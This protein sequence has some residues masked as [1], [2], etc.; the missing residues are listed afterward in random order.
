MD[1]TSTFLHYIKK[2]SSTN[3]SV[4][5]PNT[6]ISDPEEHF[7][8]LNWVPYSGNLTLKRS[9]NNYENKYVKI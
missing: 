8:A 3:F 7:A 1:S 4:E 5:G 9:E 2:D 6:F